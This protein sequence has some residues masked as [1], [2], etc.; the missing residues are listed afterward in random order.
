MPRWGNTIGAYKFDLDFPRVIFVLNQYHCLVRG[1]SFL[2][3]N[4]GVPLQ[5][6]K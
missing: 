3:R 5:G 6:L 4:L 2:F 1:A